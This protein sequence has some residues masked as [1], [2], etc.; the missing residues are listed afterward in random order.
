MIRFIIFISSYLILMTIWT[1]GNLAIHKITRTYKMY[2][3]GRI[4]YFIFSMIIGIY[5]SLIFNF[6]IFNLFKFYISIFFFKITILLILAN[7][8]FSDFGGIIFLLL[9]N[10]NYAKL[11]KNLSQIIWIKNIELFGSKYYNKIAFLLSPLSE[12]IIFRGVLLPFLIY[13]F[14]LN[15]I[16][17]LLI[18]SLLFTYQQILYLKNKYQLLIIGISSFI[19]SFINGIGVILTNS[20]IPAIIAHEIFVILYIRKK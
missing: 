7:I 19:I 2:L 17:S 6:D 5:F 18:T 8:S 13:K 9:Y 12:E 1:L 15:I 20:I 11:Y 4:Y 16:E 3:I 10:F 14:N